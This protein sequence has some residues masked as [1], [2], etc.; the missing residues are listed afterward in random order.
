MFHSVSHWIRTRQLQS[1]D[2]HFSI[3]DTCTITAA[4]SLPMRLLFP[5]FLWTTLSP[6]HVA[7]IA[8]PLLPLPNEYFFVCAWANV[9]NL[10]NESGNMNHSHRSLQLHLSACTYSAVF[11]CCLCRF[12]IR[13]F[14]SCCWRTWW[15][16]SWRLLACVIQ[17]WLLFCRRIWWNSSCYYCCWSPLESV[18][19]PRYGAAFWFLWFSCFGMFIIEVFCSGSLAEILMHLFFPPFFSERFLPLFQATGSVCCFHGNPVIYLCYCS[20]SVQVIN[21][22]KYCVHLTILY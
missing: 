15:V 12:L 16:A 18:P 19:T 13:H 22:N 1:P 21:N 10:L 14:V 6:S 9:P 8:A 11:Y 2:V 17:C 4:W 20:S 7:W 5:R 3:P